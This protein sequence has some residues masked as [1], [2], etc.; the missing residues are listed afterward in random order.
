M[1]T[2]SLYIK[3][4]KGKGRGVFSNLPLKKNCLIERCPLLVIP[5]E[6]FDYVHA[7]QV[8]NYSFFLNKKEKILALALGFGSL[9]NHSFECNA[10]HIID[11]ENLTIDFIALDDIDTNVEITINY[12]GDPDNKSIEW[13]ETRNIKYRF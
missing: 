4:I 2:P 5:F 10:D 8:V 12:N 6:D 13:F 7:T 3:K 11:K 1:N 9:Y